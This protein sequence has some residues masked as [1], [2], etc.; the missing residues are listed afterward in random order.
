M[1][2]DNRSGAIAALTALAIVGGSS[3]AMAAP[4]LSVDLNGGPITSAS[5]TTEGFNG[6]TVVADPSGNTW[7]PWGGPTSTGGDGTQ[8]PSSQSSPTVGGSSITKTFGTTTVTISAAGTLTNYAS[9]QPINSRDRGNPT[10][11]ADLDDMYRDF[12]FGAVSGSNVQGTNYLQ[13]TVSGLTPDAGYSIAL[14]SY[15][16][17]SAH[18]SNWT[19]TAPPSSAGYINS[20]SGA[21]VPPAD[22]QTITWTTAAS[23]STDLAGPAPAVFNVET[24]G[25]GTF[26]VWGYGGSGLAG[27]NNATN[28]YLNGF[29]IS[30]AVPEPASIGLL[31]LGALGLISRRRKA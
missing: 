22:E 28:T 23:G 29:Q 25:T 7:S 26:S 30:A 27:D 2:L 10:G 20:T 1:W 12:I 13:V 19:A 24:D 17:A 15:D 9:G 8:L 5:C 16:S 6:T 11:A 14:Y 3:M 4:F 21:F 18:S 31:G